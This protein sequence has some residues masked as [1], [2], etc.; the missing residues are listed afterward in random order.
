M[1]PVLKV[2]QFVLLSFHFQTSSMS[3]ALECDID[4]L[5]A[6]AAAIEISRNAA[7]NA[8]ESDSKLERVCALARE[9]CT[10]H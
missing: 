4:L 9:H 3:Y 5:L 2:V 10:K 8:R 1:L 6:D 7:S